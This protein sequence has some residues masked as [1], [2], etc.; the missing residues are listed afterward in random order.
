MWWWF[1]ASALGAD[2]PEV[3]GPAELGRLLDDAETGFASLAPDVFADRLDE[4]ALLLPCLDAVVAPSLAARWHGLLGLRLYTA[5]RADDARASFASAR[6]A[7]S[8]WTLSDRLIPS[9]HDARTLLDGPVPSATL[10]MDP[11]ASGRLMVDGTESAA[12]PA[13]RPAIVQWVEGEVVSFTSYSWPADPLP[14]YDTGVPVPAPPEEPTRDRRRKGW[15]FLVMGGV[16]AGASAALYGL[17]AAGQART[18]TG[19]LDVDVDRA[20]LEAMQTRTNRLV[21]ASGV[22]AGLA[23]AGLVTF[24]VVR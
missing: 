5:G 20:E 22:T 9:V 4:A 15:P 21:T 23:A 8:A 24:V 18:L 7:D 16:A 19:T 1:A 6:A 2:C 12:R 17:G 11:P 3:V 14:A 13:E 10:P